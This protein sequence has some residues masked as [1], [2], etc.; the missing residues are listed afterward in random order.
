M[1]RPSIIYFD[2]HGVLDRRTFPGLR[3]AIGQATNDAHRVEEEIERSLQ[4]PYLSNRMT[5]K[6]FWQQ[7]EQQFGHAAATAGKKYY[8]H[9][10]PIR[11]NWELVNRL[12]RKVGLG[13]FTDCPADKMQ[14]I[15][16]SYDLPEFFDVLLLSCDARMTKSE[17]EFYHLLLQNGQYTPEEV[18]VIDRNSRNTMTA[19]QVGIP[20]FTYTDIP[21]LEHFLSTL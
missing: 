10:D 8:L 6:D 1:L 12:A 17:P 18:L 14:A 21:S 3:R 19:Q 15:R 16:N 2:Y 7:V 5:P 13:L 11:Q 4:E 20:S 9:I